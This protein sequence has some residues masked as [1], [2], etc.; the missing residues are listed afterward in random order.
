M[1][2]PAAAIIG[3]SIIGA[4]SSLYGA[5]KAASAAK[6]ASQQATDA[7]LQMFNLGRQDLAPYRQA[8][9]GALDILSQLYGIPGAQPAPAGAPG[10][11]GFAPM[12]FEGARGDATW[13]RLV[14]GFYNKPT[15]PGSTPTVAPPGAPTSRDLSPFFTSPQYQ[16]VRDEGLRG[17][18]N[19][20]AVSGS[21]SG[22][23]AI[24]GAVGYASNLASGE[25]QS[26]VDR[27]FGIAGLGS[28]ATQVGVQ[29]GSNAGANL[30]N[31]YQNAGNARASAY[32]AGA[33]GVNAA[34]Q[35]GLQNWALLKYL[36]S[37]TAGAG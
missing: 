34:V 5:S 31:I 13:K 9:Y 18:T 27:L 23:N 20:R 37:G 28:G 24:R 14:G 10:P 6:K 3:G 35:G 36:N 25:F 16:F 32:M 11:E 26:Y 29:A 15:A 8:G 12:P 21:G 30:A 17:I 33:S 4:G 1:P 19:S 2:N 7:Q 22:G